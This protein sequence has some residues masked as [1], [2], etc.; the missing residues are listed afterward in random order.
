[1][2][3][4]S[5][6]IALE[7]VSHGYRTGDQQLLVLKHVTLDIWRGQ[8]CV[9]L[10]ASGSG[11]STLL[12][13]LGLLDRPASGQFHFA[14]R[15][16]QRASTDELASIR[17][18]EIG[19]VFQSFNL[20]PRLTA[21]DNVALPLSYRG[22][23]RHAARQHAMEQLQRVGLSE[24]AMHRPAE[25]S[26]GQCQ[27]VAIARALIGSPSLILADEPTGNLDNRTA[28]DILNRLLTL[29]REHAAT[30]IMV[31]HDTTLARHFDRQLEIHQGEMHEVVAAGDDKH[32]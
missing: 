32:A 5:A 29:N 25:L 31:T 21:L 11:K 9:I 30:L 17:N 15:D 10:G 6:M 22:V 14:G 3:D 1:M 8:S 19:F 27:R 23:S 7:G 26:G 24:R 2:R 28:T 12:N 20:L 18:Q 4:T 13:I 16:M